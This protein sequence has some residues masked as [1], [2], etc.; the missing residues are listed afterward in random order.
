MLGVT[1]AAFAGAPILIP[2][3]AAWD[4]IRMR[5]QLPALRTYLFVCQYV[6]NDTVEIL[7]AGPLW[8]LADYGT[9][10]H[11]PASQRRH[12]RLQ[13]WSIRVVARRAAQLL[14]IRVATEPD[15]DAILT[16]GPA[17]VICRHVSLFDASLPSLL[18]QQLGFHTRGVIMA[19]LLADPG[20]DL[21]YQRAGSVFIPRDNKAD[22]ATI[23]ASITTELDERTVAVIFPEGRLFRPDVLANSLGRL[24]QRDPA[25]AERLAGLR[26]LLPP[27]P[28]GLNALLDAAPDADVVVINHAGLDR[29]P[30]LMSIARSAPL[31][32]SIR[33]TAQRISRADIPTNPEAR[34]EWLDALWCRMDE[35]VDAALR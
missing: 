16:P 2:G 29:H 28:G 23:A 22:A 19:E 15:I 21:L 5:W 14:G 9:T 1:C 34:V 32:G 13:A 4:V 8:L 11:R 31:R 6:F 12:Q 3:A 10:L 26:H 24:A 25:R 20:F 33:V 35:W 27:R 7:A 30:T 17:I 18:Y